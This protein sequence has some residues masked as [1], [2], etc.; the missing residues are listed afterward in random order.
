MPPK[1]QIVDELIIALRDQRVLDALAAVF[2]SKLTSAVAELKEDNVNKAAQINKLQHDLHSA[3]ARI[4]MLESYTRRDN[5]LIS[6]LPIETYS[7]AAASEITDDEAARSEAKPNI[8]VEQSVLKLFNQQLGVPTKPSDISIAH[9]LKRRGIVSGPPTTIVKFTNRKA[10]EAVYAA[11][12]KLRNGPTRIYINED[13]NKSTAEL[14]RHA[15]QLVR[16]KVIYS[17]WTSSCSVYIKETG[18]LN[19]RPKKVLSPADLPVAQ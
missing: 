9:R 18:D 13:L 11:R 6:G 14:F 17:T 10:R 2:E 19:C 1:L 5:L 8:T 3:V 7:E 4:V 15:R 12:R 16:S